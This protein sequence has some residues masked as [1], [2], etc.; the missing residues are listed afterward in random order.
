M[1]DPVRIHIDKERTRG[2]GRRWNSGKG[3]FS[4]GKKLFTHE[5][6]EVLTIPDLGLIEADASVSGKRF[7]P[8]H[9]SN[10]QREPREWMEC[11]E[12]CHGRL[13]CG[14]ACCESFESWKIFSLLLETVI[15]VVVKCCGGVKVASGEG[16]VQT[17]LR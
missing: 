7:N 12:A 15:F 9:G 6:F 4:H 10:L 11:C 14:S 8:D 13:G 16:L 1:I 5:E 3:C 2:V 17:R